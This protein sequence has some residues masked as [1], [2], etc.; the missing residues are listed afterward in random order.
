M[1]DLI[2]RLRSVDTR[3]LP[4]LSVYLGTGLDDSR[5]RGVR[6]KDLIAPIR[7]HLDDLDHDS[8]M[9]LRADLDNVV[10]AAERALEV[11]RGL[12]V[13]A[14]SGAGLLESAS[15]PAPVRD[16]AVVG[17]EPYVRPIEA[18][19]EELHEY[20]AVVVDRRRAE[21]FRFA[22]DTLSSW[23]VMAE[24]EVR[25]SNF[26][27]FGGYEER[28]VRTHAD[29]VAGRLMRQV[30]ERVAALYRER[31]F[32]LLILGGRRETVVA[33]QTELPD[34]V[35][36]VLA[37]TFSIDTHTLTPAAVLEACR[38]VAA[39]YDAR[40]HADKVD[41]LL[42]T[43]K[44]GGLAVIGL[45]PTLAAV[46]QRAVDTLVVDT[47]TT[48][49]GERCRSC[50]WVA[51]A[52]VACPACGGA[53][54]T[55]PDVVDAAAA[56]VRSSGGSVQHILVDTDLADHTMGAHLRFQVPEI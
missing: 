38:R 35:A 6:I 16:R 15:L 20:C 8:A 54:Q 30:A 28:R 1:L 48:V 21:I 42:D 49:G 40:D 14:C 17:D 55:V 32:D 51:T 18:M 44:S 52:M 3:R 33:L 19:L 4:V 56:A 36:G 23:E 9:S 25:K 47:A 41:R 37:G 29:E 7:S 5:E 53:P 46:N 34:D 39:E 31:H 50:G 45:E 43:T 11:G 22:H 2:E 27:G 26:G 24:E 13:F 12:A 10:A